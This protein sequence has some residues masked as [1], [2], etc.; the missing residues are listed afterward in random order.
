[1]YFGKR[2]GAQQFG[3]VPRHQG[4]IDEAINHYRQALEIRPDLAEAH[5]NLGALLLD[6]WTR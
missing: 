4:R 6:A 5:N 2:V 3:H 1:M